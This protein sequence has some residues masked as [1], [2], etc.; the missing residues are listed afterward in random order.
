M[1]EFY[2]LRRNRR[3][4]IKKSPPE[5]AVTRGSTKSGISSPAQGPSE[6]MVISCP[7]CGCRGK[8]RYDPLASGQEK[9]VVCPACGNTFSFVLPDK[10][11]TQK[12]EAAP[13]PGAG[14]GPAVC[15]SC[16]SAIPRTVPSCPSCGRRIR[17]ITIHCPSCQSTNVT[18]NEG[19]LRDG[20]H[21]GETT[22]FVPFVLPPETVVRIKIPLRC[23][24]CGR[25]WKVEP[26]VSPKGGKTVGSPK[27]GR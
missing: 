13:P 19:D 4:R 6:V 5:D 22:L 8:I 25:S 10:S 1:G 9:K 20:G 14:A 2:R 24:D 7:A 26:T 17:G 16:G 15:P 11:K 18:I 27:G 21:H 3:L 23:L 12:A